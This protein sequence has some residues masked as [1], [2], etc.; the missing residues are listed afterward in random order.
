[1]LAHALISTFEPVLKSITVGQNL[2]VTVAADGVWFM[3]MLKEDKEVQ[4]VRG[5]FRRFP[6][7]SML[8]V[9]SFEN[10]VISGGV[11]GYL[12]F[13]KIKAGECVKAIKV[14]EC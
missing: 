2:H 12:Y 1:M 8:C 11:D 6:K 5:M 10:Y 13:W 7:T 3:R 14:A 9:V 4:I